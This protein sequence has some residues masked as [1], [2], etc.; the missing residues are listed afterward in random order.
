MIGW[1]NENRRGWRT[2][3]SLAFRIDG[4]GGKFWMFYEYGTRNWRTG[5]GGAFEGEQYQTTPTP[6]FPAD[7]KPH[8]GRSTTIRRAPTGAG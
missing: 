7:G 5:G 8:A 4:N 6:P 1:F 3:N 2:P